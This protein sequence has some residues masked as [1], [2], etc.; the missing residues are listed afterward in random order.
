M[1]PSVGEVKFITKSLTGLTLEERAKLLFKGHES[2]GYSYAIKTEQSHKEAK[3]YMDLL[4]ELG[5]KLYNVDTSDAYNME[6]TVVFRRKIKPAPE[7]TIV[8]GLLSLVGLKRKR[9][10]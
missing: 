9:D 8:D 3:E 10:E 7:P 6:R 4:L 2:A 1:E 5:F